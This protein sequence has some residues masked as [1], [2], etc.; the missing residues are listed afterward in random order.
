MISVPWAGLDFFLHSIFVVHSKHLSSLWKQCC[1]TNP[2]SLSLPLK[3]EVHEGDNP[4]WKPR[5]NLPSNITPSFTNFMTKELLSDFSATVLQVCDEPFD[6]AWVSFFSLSLS[7]SWRQLFSNEDSRALCRQVETIPNV[8][9]E[10]PTGYSKEFG[11]E[12][13]RL[14]EAL[15]EPT[16][17]KVSGSCFSDFF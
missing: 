14:A 3:E 12:R 4:K 10:F 6:L 9:Y 8:C 7:A 1:A 2:L 16:I 5:P 15:F 13:F 17:L 11:P